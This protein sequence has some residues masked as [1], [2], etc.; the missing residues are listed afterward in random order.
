MYISEVSGHHN[1]ALAI[2]K[3][4]KTLSP[5]TEVLNINAFK[6]TN[7]VSEKVV[8]HLYMTVI[9]KAPQIWDYL[10]DNPEVAR[11]LENIKQ[12]IHKF[13]SPKFKNLFDDF[14]P[15]AVAC[16]QAFPC[17]MVADYKKTYKSDLPLVAVLTDY[18]PHAYWIY[19]T[20]DYYIVPS[21]DVGKNLEKKGVSPEKIKPF[22]IPFDLKFNIPVDKSGIMKKLKLD[23][24]APV[25][26]I[27]GGGHGLGPIQ[28]II[29][30]LE[31]TDKEIQEI[32]IA[33]NNARL[34]KSLKR[35]IKKCRKN[36]V[37]F[38][39]VNNIHELMGISS[40]IITKPG[41]ITIAESMAKALP[42]IIIKPIPGQETSNTIYLTQR[43]AAIK[44]GKPKNINQ[45]VESL[46]GNPQKLERLAEAARKIAKPNASLD[47]A[48]LL[49]KLCDG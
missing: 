40:L 5:E 16:T 46:L 11:K 26:L 10:Y 12:K 45:V 6:Y 47:T 3:A 27:M 17:G 35:S 14:K 33:G 41:G 48:K 32:I 44:V 34:Y 49:L 13:N 39:Y 19:D 42:M 29:K 9:K 38:R 37:L 4:L 31:K 25:I 22:G 30:S 36:I 15:D 21:E 28:T 7:P 18:I 23:P 43:G 20:V 8:N 1:A 24:G 2:E